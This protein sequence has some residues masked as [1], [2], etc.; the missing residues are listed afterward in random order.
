[1]PPEEKNT[2]HRMPYRERVILAGGDHD[3]EEHAAAPC[4]LGLFLRSTDPKGAPVVYWRTTDADARGYTIFLH[5]DLVA[6]SNVV[7]EVR[8]LLR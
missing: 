2:R 6:G 8:R 4:V 3:G 7:P 1:M 5:E